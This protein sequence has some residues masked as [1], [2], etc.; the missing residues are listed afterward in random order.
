MVTI[1]A[2]LCT[3]ISKGVQRFKDGPSLTDANAGP[4]EDRRGS[5]KFNHAIEPGVPS[6]SVLRSAPRLPPLKPIKHVSGDKHQVAYEQDHEAAVDMRNV[7]FSVVNDHG[8]DGH[9][10]RDEEG[11]VFRR[12]E[13]KHCVV[14]PVR[15]MGGRGRS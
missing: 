15:P 6:T 13:S 4:I 8:D 5:I 12:R 7:D 14:P 3:M 10:D 1:M 2:P 11:H 9:G